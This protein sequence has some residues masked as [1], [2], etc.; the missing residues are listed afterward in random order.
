MTN[1]H[2]R[3]HLLLFFYLFIKMKLFYAKNANFII[4][5]FLT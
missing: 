1:K 2:H 3:H 5:K 4:I